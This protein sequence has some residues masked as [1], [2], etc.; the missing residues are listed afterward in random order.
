[1]GAQPGFVKFYQAI[2]ESVLDEV[3]KLM[4]QLQKAGRPCTELLVS[5]H[6]LGGALANL[7]AVDLAAKY[8]DT[9]VSLWTYGCM[10]VFA[11]NTKAAAQEDDSA[12]NAHILLSTKGNTNHRYMADGD[13]APPGNHGIGTENLGFMHCG[14][15]LE[16][17]SGGSGKSKHC[18]MDH[19]DTFKGRI[20]AH[21][22]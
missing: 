8:P 4:S 19:T 10:R 2:R 7:G 12:Y 22:L 3:D 16:L 1:M 18:G 21:Y 5:G 15:G 11:E 17:R 20:D 14:N 9:K 6:S 13:F